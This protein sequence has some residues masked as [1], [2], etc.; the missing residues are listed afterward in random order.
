[1]S[2][3]RRA[4]VVVA[5]V[6][7]VV[8]VVALLAWRASDDASSDEPGARG[9]AGVVVDDLRDARDPFAALTEGTVTVGGRAVRVV[10]ADRES[11]RVVGLRGRADADPYEGMLFVFDGDTTTAFTMAG[12]PAPLDIAF[13]DDSG[14][15]VDR[16]RMEPCAGT[17][18]SCP[19]YE[20]SDAFRYVL[21]TAAGEMPPGSLRV[22]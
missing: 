15:R 13:F 18:V 4:A 8:A 16:L 21:E 22:R 9:G 1:V 7:L 11:E 6:L 5:G 19:L 14:R 20:A 12:V 17:D 3:A 2:G 10:I